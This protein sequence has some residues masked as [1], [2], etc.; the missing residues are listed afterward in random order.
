MGIRAAFDV[1][2]DAGSGG[3]GRIANC[4]GERPT[5]TADE[6]AL[7]VLNRLAYGPAAGDLAQVRQIGVNAYIVGKLNPASIPLPADLQAPL[8]SLTT[9]TLPRPRHSSNTAPPPS[10]TP[11]NA[12]AEEKNRTRQLA[13]REMTLQTHQAR[14][15]LAAES[16]R[17]LQE[18]M[19]EFWFWFNY[20]NIFEGKG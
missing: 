10:F 18:V 1:I 2:R 7:H 4:V 15:W 20:F 9:Y 13:A 6:R 5:L 19:T 12:S 17:Q 11:Y 16:P 8:D 14:I 3:P